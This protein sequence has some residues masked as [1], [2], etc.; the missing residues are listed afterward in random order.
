M[1]KTFIVTEP[2]GFHARPATILASTAK[3]F[4]DEEGDVLLTY[5]GDTVK[6]SSMMRIMGLGIKT[7]TEFTLEG[8]EVVITAIEE[9]LKKANIIA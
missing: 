5:N 4:K 8:S 6:A 7:K 9:A 2:S 3:K 1:E